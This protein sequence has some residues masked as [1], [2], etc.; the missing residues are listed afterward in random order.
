MDLVLVANFQ[1]RQK[2]HLSVVYS[3]KARQ[4]EI[5][6]PT[7]ASV[8]LILIIKTRDAEG[9]CDDGQGMGRLGASNFNHPQ[10]SYV[11]KVQGQKFQ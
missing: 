5:M 7:A 1:E 4:M 11:D 6:L 8:Y 9:K 3:E 10:V 2:S